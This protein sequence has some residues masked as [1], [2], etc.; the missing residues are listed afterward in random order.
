MSRHVGMAPSECEGN[1]EGRGITRPE[2]P[3][4]TPAVRDLGHAE[5]PGIEEKTASTIPPA[6]FISVKF[7]GT[8]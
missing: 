7:R 2:L 3:E 6:I 4:I 8:H 1:R 5:K